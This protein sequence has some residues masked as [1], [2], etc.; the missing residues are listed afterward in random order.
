ML[1]FIRGSLVDADMNHAVVDVNGLGYRAMIPS[2]ILASLPSVGQEVFLFTSLIIRETAH[3]LYGFLRTQERDLFEV[4]IGISGIGPK[5]A[6]ALVGSFSYSEI[7]EAVA[8]N[9]LK[10]ICKVPG[11]GKKTAERLIIEVRDKLPKLLLTLDAIPLTKVF[12]GQSQA[13]DTMRDAICALVNLGYK[14]SSAETAI[15]QVLAHS[16]EAPDVS[17]L[18][19]QAMK[20]V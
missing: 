6:I 3:S 9:D 14:R 11:I 19:T 5:T 15:S 2:N 4:F 7:A 17:S 1:E 20:F 10:T 13:T 16:D 12:P 8:N 18:I